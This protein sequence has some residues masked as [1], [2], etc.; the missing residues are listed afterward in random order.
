MEISTDRA[1]LDRD[2]IHRF[3]SQE[4]YWAGYRTRAQNDRVIERSLCF[5]AYDDGGRQVGF[6]RV[7]GDG[8]AFGYVADVF[9]V[10]EARGNGV[11]KALMAAL[12]AHPEVRELRRLTLV[13]E[14]AHGLYAG[15][16]FEPL[17]DVRRWMSRSA[18]SM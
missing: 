3:L 4:S 17:D 8:V 2:L 15:F 16:G 18:A 1:R 14:D 5:G 11:G 10:P 13:T 9:V 6:A 12:L 7:V